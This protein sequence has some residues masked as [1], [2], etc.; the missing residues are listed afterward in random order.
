MSIKTILILMAIVV[1]LGL[2]VNEYSKYRAT[3]DY[4][5]KL[6]NNRV[7]NPS[8]V[9]IKETNA[10]I[11]IE[12]VFEE[13]GTISLSIKNT[14]IEKINGG[15]LKATVD[16]NTVELS[17]CTKTLN[18]SA[19]CVAK[20]TNTPFP[21]QGTTITIGIIPDGSTEVQYKCAGGRNYC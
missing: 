15:S 5:E 6:L 16:G 4:T 20:L 9:A 17:N 13:T 21:K 7:D 11:S 1:F 2:A 12:S 14:G 18:P 3:T 8:D 19:T 10:Q